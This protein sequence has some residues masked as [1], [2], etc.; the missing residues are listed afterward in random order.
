MEFTGPQ[1]TIVTELQERIQQ[2]EYLTDEFMSRVCTAFN[3][4]IFTDLLGVGGTRFV[5]VHPEL[6][7]DGSA[8]VLKVA[9]KDAGLVGNIDEHRLYNESPDHV[10]QHLG[11]CH[12]VYFDGLILEMDAYEHISEND[13]PDYEAQLQ[14]I[15]EHIQF[16]H[17]QD[18]PYHHS[19][20]LDDDGKLMMIDYG[21]TK[22]FVLKETS[23]E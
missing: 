8:K 4:H 12:G 16:P 20:G 5:I 18:P 15:L 17:Y 1:Q 9:F 11:V 10:K 6:N 21:E 3:G 13:F 23:A 14:E 7:A 19:F 2:S 22:T